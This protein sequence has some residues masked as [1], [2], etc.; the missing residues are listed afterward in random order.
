[1]AVQIITVKPGTA[2]AEGRDHTPSPETGYRV[3]LWERHEDHPGGEIFITQDS[4]PM[5]VALTPKVELCL[6]DGRLV[7]HH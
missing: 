3:L 1:V 4:E 7:Q 6:S 5:E 2:Q